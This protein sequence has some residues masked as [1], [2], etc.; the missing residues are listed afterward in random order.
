MTEQQDIDQKKIER[1]KRRIKKIL[2]R[3]NHTGQSKE[4]A[5]AAAALAHELMAQ[6]QIE[7]ADLRD[8]AGEQQPEDI[9]QHTVLIPNPG[10]TGRQRR[11]AFEQIAMA[12]GGVT[13]AWR[14]PDDN[15]STAHY[16]IVAFMPAS[17]AEFLELMWPAMVLQAEGMLAQD[18]KGEREYLS[19][20]WRTQKEIN[21]EMAR[22]R[23]DWWV[24][25]GQR[26]AAKIRSVRAKAFDE[27]R[28]TGS[29]E[30]VLLSDHERSKAARDKRFTKLRTAKGP[31]IQSGAGLNAG[32][33]AGMRT[34]IGQTELADQGAMSGL[35]G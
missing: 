10:N 25:W 13:V 29:G 24:G 35:G 32:L 28:G 19:G 17:T 14:E 1:M 20:A 15:G 6:Y 18:A 21:R 31:K 27:A 26:T 34:L 2:D 16:T 3:A 8:A 33:V 4:E 30:L 9:V 11:A 5:E 22:F 12:Y 23:R 7:E